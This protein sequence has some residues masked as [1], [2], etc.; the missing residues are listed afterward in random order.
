MKTAD[1]RPGVE[2]DACVVMPNHFH[3]I[4]VVSNDR[5]TAIGRGTA[6]RAPTVERFGQPVSGSIPTVMRSFK[7]A[8]T[9][10]IN[11]MHQTPGKPLWQRN[12]Y[13]HVIRNENELNRI[14]QYII[15]NPA[16]WETDHENPDAANGRDMANCRG[17]ARRAPTV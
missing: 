10:R 6:R 16:K 8:V 5:G 11:E 3:G 13:E 14:R 7:S 17:T 2:L 12:Y 9:K 15:D 1:I 4:I